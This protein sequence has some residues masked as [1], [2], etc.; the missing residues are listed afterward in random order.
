MNKKIK[1]FMFDFVP[2]KNKGEEAILRGIED[3]LKHQTN[4]DIE[5]YFFDE[6]KKVTVLNN[7]TLLPK[8]WIF[9]SK[10][11]SNI[12][13]KRLIKD[14]TNKIAIRV[15]YFLATFL[16][17]HSIRSKIAKHNELLKL[18]NQCDLVLAGHDGVFSLIHSQV[19]LYSKS[20]NKS[21]GTFGAGGY[22]HF[23]K[24]N[25]I[26][27]QLLLKSINQADF[28]YVRE[29]GV[30]KILNNL[31]GTHM[32]KLAPDPAFYM[33]DLEPNDFQRQ[34]K[35]NNLNEIINKDNYINVGVTIAHKRCNYLKPFFKSNLTLEEILNLHTTYL[36]K[37]FD[38]L[39]GLNPKIKLIFLPHSL[40]IW[41]KNDVEAARRV[42]QSMKNKN[43]CIL[44]DKD[45]TPR[46]LKAFIRN[47]DF[48]IG[49]R[50]HSMIGAASVKTPYAALV[51][52]N[53]TRTIDILGKMCEQEDSILFMDKTDS[54]T[55][56][57]KLFKLIKNRFNIKKDLEL[58]MT[59]MFNNLIDVQKDIHS[60]I[61]S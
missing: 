29:E 57:S 10:A 16:N 20:I 18:F 28:F 44:I 32:A 9:K 21:V 42:I 38:E 53:D 43:S 40:E 17:V 60:S 35:E 37:T 33:A 27:K 15:D 19:I 24:A 46:F 56:A 6:V 45:L 23:D 26:D 30:I 49:Q 14:I 8:E 52:S 25:W 13:L 3:L 12:Y 39:V 7:F 31:S 59:S 34:L 51:A 11:R 48:I 58:R 41:P 4:N 1:I 5:M 22:V 47:L 54:I 2:L 36:A 50:A 61:K 55:Q